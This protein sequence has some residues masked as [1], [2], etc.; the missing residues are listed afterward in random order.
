M[1]NEDEQRYIRIFHGDFKISEEDLA[2]HY[3]VHPSVIRTVVYGAEPQVRPYGDK[4]TIE[5]L[6]HEWVKGEPINQI[7]R[8]VKMRRD[9]LRRWFVWYGFEF[10]PEQ[11]QQ[12]KKLDTCYA[13]TS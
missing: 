2:K 13:A 9:T 4:D 7:A 3:Q 5:P 10:A 11:Y 12:R 6:F 1:L 8:R